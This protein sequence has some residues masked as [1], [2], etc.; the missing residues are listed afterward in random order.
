[1]I[2]KDNQFM[3]DTDAWEYD[4]TSKT[5]TPD[6]HLAVLRVSNDKCPEAF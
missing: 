2:S 3:Y 5:P 1:M 6:Y 4:L